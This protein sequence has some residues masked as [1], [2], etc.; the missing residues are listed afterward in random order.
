MWRYEAGRGV[1]T[2]RETETV[3]RKNGKPG[4]NTRPKSRPEIEARNRGPK[5]RPEIEARNRG[6]KERR[7][8]QRV[9]QSL[10]KYI[11]LQRSAKTMTTS[12]KVTS[13][14]HTVRH[15]FSN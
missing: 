1:N 8:K 2:L 4:P 7:V 15:V 11:T 9:K 12:I 5:S 10:K 14:S 6:P 3:P 13:I